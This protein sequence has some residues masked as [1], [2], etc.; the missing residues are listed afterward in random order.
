M[1][2]T[3]DWGRGCENQTPGTAVCRTCQGKGKITG[4]AGTAE[5]VVACWTCGGKGW[6]MAQRIW[7]AARHYLCVG[8][9]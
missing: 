9:G 7:S 2:K 8:R 1:T 4:P 3:N 5:R 6:V